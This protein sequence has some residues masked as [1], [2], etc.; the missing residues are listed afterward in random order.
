MLR[1][2]DQ[3][4]FKT[5]DCEEE[6]MRK[7][8]RTHTWD[9][10]Q[11]VPPPKLQLIPSP[12]S[13]PPGFFFSR[14]IHPRL[15]FSVF[16]FFFSLLSSSA[17]QPVPCPL[18]SRPLEFPLCP[19]NPA[20]DHHVEPREKGRKRKRNKINPNNN[21]KKKSLPPGG[22]YSMTSCFRDNIYVLAWSCVFK[23]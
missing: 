7:A 16:P 10:L 11:N 14:K 20:P 13:F 6:Y 2:Q 19:K 15:L 9:A 18:E 17:S 12:S 8:P 3:R 5:R 4:W 22:V 23:T 21:N 1:W